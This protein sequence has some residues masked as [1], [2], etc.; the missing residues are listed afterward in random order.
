MVP[1]FGDAV[2]KSF[3]NRC[4]VH[5][6]ADKDQLVNAVAVYGV[7]RSRDVG[8]HGEDFLSV[9][10][11]ESRNPVAVIG[12][13]LLLAALL[14]NIGG[15]GGL[16]NPEQ[17]LRADNLLGPFVENEVLK[18][19]LIK[20]LY[21]LINKGAD[22]VFLGFAFLVMMVVMVMMTVVAVFLMLLVMVVFIMVL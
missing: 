4:L 21:I 16:G 19:L 2:V 20:G 22:A 14:E 6:S 3:D 15:V 18:L 12:G 9:L 7:P 13:V 8:I 11:G 1:L 5:L 17:T 10:L